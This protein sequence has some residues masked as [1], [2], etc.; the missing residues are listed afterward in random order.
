[1]HTSKTKILAIATTVRKKR[2]KRNIAV[3]NNAN[4]DV[5]NVE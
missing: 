2:N 4:V 1:M 5:L 3:L